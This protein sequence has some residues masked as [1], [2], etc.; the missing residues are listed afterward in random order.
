MT[1]DPHQ[2]KPRF[3]WRSF[4]YAFCGIATLFRTAPNARVH[5]IA[6]VLALAA[7][8]FLGISAAEWCIIIICIGM[9]ISAEAVNSA[10]EFLADRISV[11]HHPLLKNTKDVAAA[12][13]LILAITAAAVGAII[14]IPKI[15]TLVCQS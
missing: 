9:V 3:H 15:V 11:K 7:G 5:V 4:K 1:T 10:I 12:A 8:Y 6:A 14:F 2:E 13:V